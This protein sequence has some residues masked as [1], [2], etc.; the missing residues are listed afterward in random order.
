MDDYFGPAYVDVDEWR[1]EPLAHRYVHGGFERT[2]TR[3]SF[4]FPP[5]EE[6]RGRFLHV[7]EGGTG[8][9]ESTV[10]GQLA[11]G[12]GLAL[13]FALGAYL[14][15][16][17]QGHLG[18]DPE[19]YLRLMAE[20][21][22][23][24]LNYRASVAS[25]LHARELAAE[26]YGAVPRHGYVYGGSGGG[27]RGTMIF[28][29]AS[30][31]YDGA[32]PFV[33]GHIR[34]LN[35]FSAIAHAARLLRPALGTI[36]DAMQPGGSGNP[37]DGLTTDQR[38]VLAMLYRLGFPR[39]AEAH[40]EYAGPLWALCLDVIQDGDPSYYDDFWS[41]PGYAGGDS[42]DGLGGARIRRTATVQKRVTAGELAA[43]EHG[44]WMLA[45]SL[46]A[47]PPEAI[48]G[49]SL[50][51]DEASALEMADVTVVSGGSAGASV[52]AST[53]IDEVI[54]PSRPDLVTA[55]DAGDE[56]LVD[57]RRFLAFS[58][59][60]RHQNEPYVEF[61]QFRVDGVP[62]YPVRP[63]LPVSTTD[64]GF[65][66]RFAGKMI[67][68]MNVLDRGCWPNVGYLYESL[69]RDQLGDSTDGRFRLWW[70]EHADHIPSSALPA[71]GAPVPSTC[72]IDYGGIVEQ[73]VRDVV[74]WVEEGVDPAGS[75][76]YAVSRDVRLSLAETAGARRG[77]QPVVDLTADGAVGATAAPGDTVSF[78]V[79]IEVPPGAGSIVAVEWD[80]DGSGTWPV[81]EP[82]DGA[83]TTLRVAASHVYDARGTYFPAVRVTSHALGNPGAALGRVT[84][85][86]RARVVVS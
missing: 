15:E 46:S 70:T 59:L 48:V 64:P 56:V 28:E 78:V 21:G 62:I 9:N 31:L 49:F 77:I 27:Q 55:L 19:S 50:D 3:F 37:F 24:I 74:A 54:V 84:N 20:G 33:T 83:A 60:Y 32:V 22:Q 53:V 7:V 86:G 6:Y 76:G 38:D 72:L 11:P 35:Y 69:V 47:M 81:T 73:A 17:N 85:L 34:T 75:T 13:P 68:I 23:S 52:V 44:N 71:V 65:T 40:I 57:N 80:F 26:M 18:A 42:T 82:M 25:A 2:D 8:G 36:V 16:S 51:H 58:F 66:G 12:T 30:D 14:V 63:Q 10:A 41:L 29:Q 79:D 61:D 43:R 45:W 1:D 5:I 39:G 67:M 4:Y